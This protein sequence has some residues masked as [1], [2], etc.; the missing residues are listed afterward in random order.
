MDLRTHLQFIRENPEYDMVF[1][2]LEVTF[3]QPVEK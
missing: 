3:V 1:D 2:H